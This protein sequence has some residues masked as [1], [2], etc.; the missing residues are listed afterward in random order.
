MIDK[1]WA[2]ITAI[3]NNTLPGNISEDECSELI[4]VLSKHWDDLPGGSETNMSADK[5]HRIENVSWHPPELQF[6][7]ERHG[8]WQYGSSRAVVHRW[9]LNIEKREMRCSSSKIRQKIS[10]AAPLDCAPIVESVL[11]AVRS[12]RFSNQL[13]EA[14]RWIEED[15]IRIV[16]SQLIPDTHVPKK[17]LEGQRRRFRGLLNVE[18]KKIGWLPLPGT[19]LR[20]RKELG[21]IAS[22]RELPAA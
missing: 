13:Y 15:E 21:S 11:N 14:V 20:F 18:L 16:V 19:A 12:G 4:A 8:G 10:R 9:T 17:T 6:D 7:I 1:P 2:E 5:L 3:L 22:L